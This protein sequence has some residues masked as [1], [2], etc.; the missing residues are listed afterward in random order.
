MTYCFN[1]NGR[2][3]ALLL[4][5]FAQNLCI[6]WLI[7][8]PRTSDGHIIRGHIFVDHAS[9]RDERAFAY[10]HRADERRA[11]AD[12]DIIFD[13]GMEFVHAIVIRDNDA[14]SDIHVFPNR[15]IAY[16][17][18]VR[19]EGAASDFRVLELIEVSYERA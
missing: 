4:R 18:E 6:S 3:F 11:R 9:R 15:R 5:L 17:G 7:L 13:G 1:Y 8:L 2:L 14:T 10:R 19:A 12:E 16:V